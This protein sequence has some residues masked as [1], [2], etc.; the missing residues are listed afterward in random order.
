MINLKF[1]VIKQLLSQLEA[2]DASLKGENIFNIEG[3]SEYL[4]KKEE[5]QL[6]MRTIQEYKKNYES[7]GKMLKDLIPIVSKDKKMA[8]VADTNLFR[9]EYLSMLGLFY[10]IQESKFL[11]GEL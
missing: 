7:Y 11:W 4:M 8:S 2:L 6:L 10:T 9:S 3:W 1:I 5:K